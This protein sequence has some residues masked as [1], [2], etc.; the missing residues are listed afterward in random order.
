MSSCGRRSDARCNRGPRRSA[1]IGDPT[2]APDA[3]PVATCKE[4][5]NSCRLVAFHEQIMT[6]EPEKRVQRRAVGQGSITRNE[7][8]P[9][10]RPG[11]G[12]SAPSARGSGVEVVESA[13]PVT[14]P[15]AHGIGQPRPRF[16]AP[17]R[18][19]PEGGLPIALPGRRKSSS[20]LTG[21]RRS[22]ASA[23][24]PRGRM[25]VF[26]AL[27]DSVGDATAPWTLCSIGRLSPSTLSP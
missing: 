2:S 8:V 12:F 1:R 27:K 14:V 17:A 18:R 13:A 25:R 6:F 10:S 23:R 24:L 20:P 26:M 15:T 9:R 11:V 22:S 5:I 7:G 4:T 16:H 19:G 3:A 21:G